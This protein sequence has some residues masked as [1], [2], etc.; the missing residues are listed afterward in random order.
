MVSFILSGRRLGVGLVQ[1]Q[2]A[3]A[4]REAASP[5]HG[6]GHDGLRGTGEDGKARE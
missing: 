4:H 2:A 3:T 6:S 1:H 5:S